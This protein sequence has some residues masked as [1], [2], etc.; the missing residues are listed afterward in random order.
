MK[1]G[2]LVVHSTGSVSMPAGAIGLVVEKDNKRLTVRWFHGN[3]L[4]NNMK[5]AET[6]GYEHG[7]EVISAVG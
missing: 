6:T 5:V 1:V 4:P 3:I 7:L 2:D